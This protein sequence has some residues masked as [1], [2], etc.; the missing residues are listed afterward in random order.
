MLKMITLFLVLNAFLNVLKSCVA[1]MVLVLRILGCSNT[2]VLHLS[3]RTNDRGG[4]NLCG[5]A[6]NSFWG[7]I[8]QHC[9][10]RW[11]G[12][13]ALLMN[14]FHMGL[15]VSFL[16]KFLLAEVAAVLVVSLS[17]DPNHVAT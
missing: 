12:C 4:R 3:N 9:Y 11:I 8:V 2:L 6:Q 14:I 16:L 15:Q 10:W 7:P 13:Y 17:V 1:I 5:P